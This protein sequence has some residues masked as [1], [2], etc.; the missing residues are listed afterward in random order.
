MA[1]SVE[2]TYSE[3]AE[4]QERGR[5]LAASVLATDAIK[6]AELE[7]RFGIALMQRRYPEVYE[8]LK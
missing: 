5:Q 2:M 3:Y 6:R 7:T 4:A 1:P 8:R